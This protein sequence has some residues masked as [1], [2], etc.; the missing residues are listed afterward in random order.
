MKP[1]KS[2]L[3]SGTVIT[4]AMVAAGILAGS[5]PLQSLCSEKSL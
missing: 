2:T 4:A 1:F 3:L 5:E